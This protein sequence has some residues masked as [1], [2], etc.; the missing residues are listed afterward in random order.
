MFVNVVFASDAIA[1]REGGGRRED[2][3][4]EEEEEHFP[5]AYQSHFAPGTRKNGRAKWREKA[6][7]QPR[8]FPLH[9]RP[10]RIDVSAIMV[11]LL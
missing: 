9:L 7:R 11:L 4:V 1:S 3:R 8:C 5:P 2:A 10:S 6:F